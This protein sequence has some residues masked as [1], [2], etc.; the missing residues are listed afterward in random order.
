[1]LKTTIFNSASRSR[2]KFAIKAYGSR[3][4]V[5]AQSHRQ[6]YIDV[7]PKIFEDIVLKGGPKPVIVDFYADWCQPCRMLSPI[8]EK[9]TGDKSTMDGKE[10]D[11]V[12]VDIDKHPELAAQYKVTSLP[13]VFAFKNGKQSPKHR[14][15]H[16]NRY[17]LSISLRLRHATISTTTHFSRRMGSSGGG[18]APWFMKEETHPTETTTVANPSRQT[19]ST[20]LPNDI[21]KH[22]ITLHKHLSQSPLLGSTPR[23]C[24][25]SSLRNLNDHIALD[26]SRPKGRRR[27]GVHD[28]GDSVG[29]PDDMWSWYV[30]AQVKEGTE[31]RG[32][33][34]SVVRSA[35]KELL[36]NH[37]DLPIPKKLSRRRASDG[38]EVL[39]IGDSLLHVVSREAA[40]KWLEGK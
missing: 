13:T 29:E 22:L 11:L 7:T 36:K 18:Q 38:W 15:S 24:K 31:G 3:H 37:P 20:S 26:Y 12:T 34:E 19:N 16:M 28:A 2:T 6:Q 25:P 40:S 17:P 23:I 39:D 9:Y 27:R 10:F 5:S 21:P 14:A 30:I 32:A 33:I 4:F 8:L 1:M 35:Q